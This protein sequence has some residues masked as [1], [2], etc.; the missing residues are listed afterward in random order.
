M[1]LKTHVLSHAAICL[2]QAEYNEAAAGRPAARLTRCNW[3]SRR[4]TLR[5]GASFELEHGPV[6]NRLSCFTANKNRRKHTRTRSQPCLSDG[7]V[8]ALSTRLLLLVHPRCSSLRL[9]LLLERRAQRRFHFFTGKFKCAFG[10]RGHATSRACANN[11]SEVVYS[12]SKH[13]P[14]RSR[15]HCQCTRSQGGL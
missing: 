7:S 5:R 1:N 11:S 6:C 8:M 2:Q 9:L 14:K 4:P 13:V 10:N 15:I 3:V 12:H